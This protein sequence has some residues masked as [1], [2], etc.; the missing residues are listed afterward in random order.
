MASNY[1]TFWQ[2][3]I[4]ALVGNSAKR[5]FPRL[6]YRGLKQ[7][8]KSVYPVDKS[9]TEIEGDTV[10]PDFGSIPSAIDAVILELPK[11]ETKDW[12]EQVREAG[13]RELWIHL[14]TESPEAVDI[15][16]KSGINLR[17]GTCAVMYLTSGFTY[18]SIHRWI[19]KM[20]GKY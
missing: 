6:T 12:V 3:K 13:I 11:E 8:G 1:E 9:V 7:L 16:E 5:A 20:M 19:M 4:Y 10:Y 15:A 17:T 2:H 18:H 14:N